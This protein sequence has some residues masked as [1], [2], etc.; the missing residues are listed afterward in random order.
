MKLRDIIANWTPAQWEALLLQY[1]LPV[2][3]L[4][5]NPGPCPI[6]GGTDRFTYDNKSG[7]GD[8]VCRKCKDGS[9]MAGD[10]LQLICRFT[11]MSFIQLALEIEGE[12]MPA[13]VAQRDCA[14][15]A[16]APRRRLDPA[17]A[18]ARLDR[19][20]GGAQPLRPGDHAMSYLSQRVR[21]LDAAPSTAIRL[22]Q[23][24]YWHGG[25][26][27]DTYWALV[28]RFT[29]P[30]GRMATLHRTYL[31]AEKPSK[32][33]I[34]CHAGEILNNKRNEVSALPLAGGAVR[35]MAPVDGVI[36]V[37]EGL[38]TAYGAYMLHGVPV[39]SCLNRVLLSQFV[40]P[41]GLGIHTVHIFADFDQIDAKTGKSPGMADALKLQSRLRAEGFTVVLHR[42][43]VRGTDF[44][45]Q[46]ATAY[47]LR[48]IA[49]R[50]PGLVIS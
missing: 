11:G 2:S 42:P 43:L 35:L 37:A 34:V 10:G 36:G 32:A 15:P 40:V 46:W 6:C 8:W 45:D 48:G 29:L 21:G 23:L 9:P 41:P 17:K 18:A 22:A 33:T 1:Q 24:E 19:I 16:V 49:A 30:D 20:W 31:D 3:C 13:P 7:R 38:E 4:T 39:W 14:R 28:C 25:K 5:G 12:R 27:L 26:V 47:S 44:C 50:A